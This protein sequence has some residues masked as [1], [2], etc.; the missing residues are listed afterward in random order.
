MIQNIVD[1]ES[2]QLLGSTEDIDKKLARIKM[3]PYP[4]AASDIC[5]A[6]KVAKYDVEKTNKAPQKGEGQEPYDY[7][8]DYLEENE[9]RSYFV[10]LAE[11]VMSQWEIIRNKYFK[12]PSASSEREDDADE[13]F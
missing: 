9:K 1:L 7:A 11:N 6:N 5:A 8:I 13:L 3:P 4:R 12:Q 2:L 10:N